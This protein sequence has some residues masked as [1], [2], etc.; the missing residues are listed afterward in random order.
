MGMLFQGQT[1]TLL[2]IELVPKNCWFRN[3]RAVL[4]QED[5][6]RVRKQTYREAGYQCEVC[7]GRGEKWPVECHEV[8]EYEESGPEK[9]QKLVR[10]IALCPD[11]HHVKHWGYAHK[12]GKTQECFNHLE[13]VNGWSH[14]QA[15]AHVKEEFERWKRRSEIEW[16]FDISSLSRYGLD[17]EDLK[18]HLE[19]KGLDVA[20]VEDHDYDAI[21]PI[22]DL[23]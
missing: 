11:C 18:A 1:R 5:W 21:I 22:E 10:L 12:Q 7:G 16:G 4:L 17:L 9:I 2:T 8:W 20:T 15:I 3:L 23:F 6:D 14:E 19:E 13:F